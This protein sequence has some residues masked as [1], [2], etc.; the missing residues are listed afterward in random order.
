MKDS[1]LFVVRFSPL[2]QTAKACLSHQ[3]AE[4]TKSDL[5]TAAKFVDEIDQ[6]LVEHQLVKQMVDL[7]AARKAEI[8]KL[9]TNA[10]LAANALEKMDGATARVILQ[11]ARKIANP[12]IQAEIVALRNISKAAAKYFA[13]IKNGARGNAL[14]SVTAS[15]ISK[16]AMIYVAVFKIRPSCSEGPFSKC[17]RAIFDECKLGR[18]PE[19]SALKTVLSGLNF[20]DL[21]QL[22]RGRKRKIK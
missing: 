17:V 18:P 14:S 7:E 10:N 8:P 20:D 9:A 6:V 5:K 22:R 2:I 3:L 19:K 12:D 15:L 13:G 16:F 1:P 4:I 11:S 21:P